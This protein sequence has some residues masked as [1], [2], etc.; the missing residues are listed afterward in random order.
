[1][2][3]D[4]LDWKMYVCFHRQLHPEHYE[5]D[6]HFDGTNYVGLKVSG[7]RFCQELD[8][9]V[10][11]E[12]KERLGMDIQFEKKFD[13]YNPVLQKHMFMASGA[14]YH[15]YKNNIHLKHKYIGFME[16]DFVLKVSPKDF[17]KCELKPLKNDFSVNNYINELV[18]RQ[19]VFILALSARWDV[20]FLTSRKNL[21]V[22]GVQCVAKCIEDFNVFFGT[23]HSL[24]HLLVENPI[25]ITQQTFLCDSGTFARIM[26]F[27][28]HVVEKYTIKNFTGVAG[29]IAEIY[30]GIALHLDISPKIYLPISHKGLHGYDSFEI[31]K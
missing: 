1:M 29:G 30:I 7:T 4:N 2:K 21:K 3:N 28:A 16:Y 23:T 12:Y 20:K 17:E 18:E 31:E 27:W 25:I 8:D 15:L 22:S 26:S 14:L 19:E 10:R 13:F 9:S 11:A 24:E 5:C 6:S